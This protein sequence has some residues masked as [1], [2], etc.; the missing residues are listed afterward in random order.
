MCRRVCL[1]RG[2]FREVEGIVWRALLTSLAGFAVFAKS[3]LSWGF[4]VWV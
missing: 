3:F 4:R 2:R 1:V